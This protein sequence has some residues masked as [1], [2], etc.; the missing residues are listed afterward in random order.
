MLTE[1]QRETL[2]KKLGFT[3]RQAIGELIYALVTC[4]P[5]IYF[6]CIKLSQYSSAPSLAHFEA[7]IKHLYKY[8][9]AT[10]DDGITYW[11]QAPNMSLPLHPDTVPQHDPNYDHNADERKQ[12]DP[13]RLTG[14][15]NSD[16]AGDNY[17]HKSV[18]G[19]CIKLAGGTIL[20][21]TQYQSTIALSTT[22][23]EFTAACKAGKY[24]LYLRSIMQEIG[25]E[26]TDATILYEDNQGA[27][28]MANAQRPTSR[29]CHMDVKHFVI[30]QWVGHDLLNLRRI[31]IQLTIIQTY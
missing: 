11:R 2:E 13:N 8:L 10:I 5:D 15:V 24:I 17:N 29:T 1:T 20:Y 27:L 14:T 7:L 26:Q 19:I 12:L 30:Q 23:A 28:L 3:Y 9:A 25:M 4:R 16:Y 31:K 22:E 18:S 21:K 6:A